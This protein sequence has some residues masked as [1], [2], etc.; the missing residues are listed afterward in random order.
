MSGWAEMP[1]LSRR[2]ASSTLP[3]AGTTTDAQRYVFIELISLL[4]PHTGK[5]GEEAVVHQA[6]KWRGTT[7]MRR[8]K[9]DWCWKRSQI[10]RSRRVEDVPRE[11]PGGDRK[12]V[13]LHG[14]G[15]H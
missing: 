6:S 2:A 11:M 3:A 9:A 15:H 1:T 7:S 12:P 14:L 13:H 8:E 5:P 10:P 4:K